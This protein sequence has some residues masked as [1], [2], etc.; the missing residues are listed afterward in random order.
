MM[1]ST[2]YFVRKLDDYVE[3]TKYLAQGDNIGYFLNGYS[4]NPFSWRLRELKLVAGTKKKAPDS[5]VDTQFFSAS[6]YKLGPEQNI[7]FSAKPVGCS[8]DATDIRSWDAPRSE[9]NFLR[10][11]LVQQLET[12]PVCYDFLVQ[13]QVAGKNMPVE[14]ATVVWKEKDSPFVPV[15]RIEIPRQAFDTDE[16]NA[17]CEALSYNP[18]HSLPEHRPIGV[19][20]RVRKALYEEVAR[21][22]WTENRGLESDAPVPPVLQSGQ[23]PE[24]NSWCIDGS[25]GACAPSISGVSN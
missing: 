23:P 16:Q 5:I 17:F 25:D 13:L 10:N 11:R 20:N 24:P 12:A 7:K 3:L 22:R 14:D 15:A 4:L 18:W 21:Y 2:N 9:Y 1:N 8:A 19:F 6:A